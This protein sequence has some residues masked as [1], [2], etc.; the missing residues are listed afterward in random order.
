[1]SPAMRQRYISPEQTVRPGTE[2]ARSIARYRPRSGRSSTKS[3]FQHPLA[4]A[5]ALALVAA[6]VAMM[7]PRQ[8]HGHRRPYGER[9]AM[10]RA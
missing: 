3:I 1:M 6:G 7:W 8:A 2:Y 9:L 5:V 10:G 4:P